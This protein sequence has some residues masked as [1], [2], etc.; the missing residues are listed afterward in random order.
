M[1][2]NFERVKAILDQLCPALDAKTGKAQNLIQLALGFLGR[3]Y[4]KIWNPAEKHIDYSNEDCQAA[5]IYEYVGANANLIYS[6]LCDAGGMAHAIF[7]Q[8]RVEVACVGGGPGTE[9]IGIFKYM[10]RIG[11][12]T[13]QLDCTILDHHAAWANSWPATVSTAPAGVTVNVNY[14]PLQMNNPSGWYTFTG[15]PAADLITFSYSLSEVWRYNGDGRVTSCL[16]SIISSARSG[17][18]LIYSDNAGASFDPHADRDLMGSADLQLLNRSDYKHMLVGA[19]EDKAVLNPYKD[20]LG[21]TV[22]LTGKA[23]TLALLRK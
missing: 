11:S 1:L 18:L 20:W 10:E 17:A 16:N 2:T 15:F 12:P 23:T 6:A 14:E 5:Y 7:Q 21:P 8:A 9:L 19:D 3:E 22:K 13:K 4:R